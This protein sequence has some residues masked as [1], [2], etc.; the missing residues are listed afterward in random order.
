VHL[1]GFTIENDLERVI[2]LG[3]SLTL[4]QLTLY[5]QTVSLFRLLA[6]DNK[7]KDEFSQ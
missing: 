5:K 2:Q 3:P 7:T 1:V 4:A 6:L